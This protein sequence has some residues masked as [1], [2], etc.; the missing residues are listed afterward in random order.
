MSD[1]TGPS[2]DGFQTPPPNAPPPPPPNMAPPPGYVPYGASTQGA[3]AT[4]QRI[5][6]LAKWLKIVLIVLIPVL[7]WTTI[8]SFSVRS[9]AKDFIANRTTEKEFKDKLAASAGIGVLSF[10]VLVAVAVLTIIWMF[11]IAKNLQ[12]MN[13]V[14]TWKPGWAIAGWFVPPLVLYVVPFL[15][16]RDLWKG[17]DPDTMHDWRTN[18]VAPIVTIWWILFGLVPLVTITATFSTFSLNNSTS[19][20]ANDLVDRFGVSIAASLAQIAA[21]LCFLVLVRQLTAR[22]QQVTYETQAS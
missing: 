20:Q 1:V 8:N 9:E 6:G 13:R 17:S 19:K 14:A 4:F 16:F 5:G 3:Y 10:V 22:H 18:R 2:S 11:R 15:M 7:L 12:A 21:A